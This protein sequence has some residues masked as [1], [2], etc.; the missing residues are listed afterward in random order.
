MLSEFLEKQLKQAQYKILKNGTY[1]GIIPGLKGVWANA[2][3]LENCRKGLREV[4]EDWLLLKVRNREKVPG[5][6]LKVDRRALVRT[7]S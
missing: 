2:K 4:L 3:N 6:D 7:N 5:F 1:F